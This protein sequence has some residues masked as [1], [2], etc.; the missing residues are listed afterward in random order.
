[1]ILHPVVQAD[2]RGREVVPLVE[3]AVLQTVEEVPRAA[4]VVLLAEEAVLL[5]E[6]L[7]LPIGEQALRIEEGLFQIN[8]LR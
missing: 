1:M 3:A 8:R 2:L 6:V 7:D 5:I 4:R